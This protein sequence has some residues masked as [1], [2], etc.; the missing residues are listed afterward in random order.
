MTKKI[1]QNI[2]D[3]IMPMDMNGLRGRMLYLPA[4]TTKRREILVV[5]DQLASIEKY[6]ELGRGLNR[7]GSVTLPDLPGFGGMQSFYKIGL[8]PTLDNYADYLAAFVKLRYKRR[9]LTIIGF[10]FG[11]G[12]VTRLLQKYPSIAKRVDLLVSEDGLVHHDDLMP[13]FAPQF[14]RLTQRV[15]SMMLPGVMVRQLCLNPVLLKRLILARY[16]R[17]PKTA[18]KQADLQLQVEDKV[19]L[20]RLNDT[21]THLRTSAEI[22]G[23]DLCN[24]KIEVP[25]YHLARQARA[26]SNLNNV[27]Q[28]MRIIYTDFILLKTGPAKLAK[29]KPSLSVSFMLP[30][31]FRKL[32]A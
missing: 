13:Q 29:A 30:V 27:E 2:A 22:L 28:H 26:N 3:F 14:L 15:G 16:G 17:Q 23:L 31:G 25:V 5:Y 4:R 10:G 11:F 12:I 8:K 24:K 19:R 18:S 1:N 21:R 9:R 20:W 7:Y 6:A 32:L